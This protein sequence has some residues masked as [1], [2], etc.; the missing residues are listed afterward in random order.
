MIILESTTKIIKSRLLA[1]L[2]S[3]RIRLGAALKFPTRCYRL[4]TDA[5]ACRWKS[6]P[7][8][9]VDES[10][11]HCLLKSPRNPRSPERERE[12]KKTPEDR[13]ETAPPDKPWCKV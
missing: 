3:S 12:R 9:P 1:P 8:Y 13:P 7:A 2:H 11:I 4:L 10:S 5:Q 6:L